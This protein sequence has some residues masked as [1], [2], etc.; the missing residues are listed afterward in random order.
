M[1][2]PFRTGEADQ[3]GAGPC[4]I[5][6]FGASGDLARRKLIPAVYALRRGG[7]IDSTNPVIGFARSSKS[8]K[9]FRTQMGEAIGKF[10]RFKDSEHDAINAFKND[11]YYQVGDYTDADSFRALGHRLD[12]FSSRHKTGDNCLFYLATPPGSFEPILKNLKVAGLVDEKTDAGQRRFR[13]V[14]V[15]KPIGSDRRSARQLNEQIHRSFSEKQVFRIDHYLGKETVQN[16]L[17][18]RFGNGIFEPLW[19]RRYVD[20]VQITV[21]ESIGVGSRAGYFNSAGITRDMLQSHILQ[22]L[23]LVA[24]EPPIAIRGEA[25]RDEKVKVLRAIRPYTRTEAIRNV[26][27]AQYLPGVVDGVAEPGYLEE[28]D[29]PADS[30]TETCVALKL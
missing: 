12:E 1:E 26:V 23:T 19:N 17:A 4:A 28:K 11:L 6:I 10:S 3:R 24:M 16:I 15:E 14:I 29:V 18:F 2:N 13:R 20:H 30:Q 9:E 8:D 22:L 25:I 21:A 5:V 7:Y 27:R